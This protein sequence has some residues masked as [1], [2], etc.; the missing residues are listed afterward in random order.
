MAYTNAQATPRSDIHALLMQAPMAGNELFIGDN[1][2]A[3]EVWLLGNKFH[4]TMNAEEGACIR[5]SS[6]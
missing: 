4:L 5:P 2:A 6:A 1:S 3:G